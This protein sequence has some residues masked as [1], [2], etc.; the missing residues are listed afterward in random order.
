MANTFRRPNL[1]LRFS[2]S[3]VIRKHRWIPAAAT[4]AASFLIIIALAIHTL[5]LVILATTVFLQCASFL[6]G[7]STHALKDTHWRKLTHLDRQQYARVWDSLASSPEGARAAACG[8]AEEKEVRRSAK[9]PLEQLLKGAKVTS[10]DDVLEIGCGV[11]RIGL[12]LATKCRHW[13]GVD[14]SPKM[15]AYAAERL[16]RLSNTSLI[17]LQE[18]SLR[19]IAGRSFDLV[20][21][22]TCSRTSTR[23]IGGAT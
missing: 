15:L 22:R 13:T 10:Q 14:I 19:G 5:V 3:L 7:Y 12:E 9:R 18:V 4:I 6:W 8:E 11:G 1:N 20:T 2:A 17:Q 23:W 21:P 16:Q